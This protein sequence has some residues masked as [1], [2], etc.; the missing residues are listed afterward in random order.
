MAISNKQ[1][2]RAEQALACLGEVAKQ[3][4]ILYIMNLPVDTA[5]NAELL[6]YQRKPEEAESLLLQH[7]PPL[8]YRAIKMNIRLF[9]W[10]HAMEIALKANKYVEIVLFYRN[11]YL[12]MINSKESI[13][14][15][16][17]YIYNYLF[18]QG[19]KINVDENEIQ[20]LK[21]QI[22]EEECNMKN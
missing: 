17:E 5:K 6:L 20:K 14:V 7:Y 21:A 3:N 18:R 12:Q 22:K 11:R 8:L 15:F 10:E 4:Y 19:Q 9:K 2:D 1:L 13:P 16:I